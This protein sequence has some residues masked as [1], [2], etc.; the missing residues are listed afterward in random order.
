M[1]SS[2]L[3]STSISDEDLVG[4]VLGGSASGKVLFFDRFSP[5]VERVLYAVLGPDPEVADVLHEVFLAAFHG[6]RALRDPTNVKAWITS[7]AVYTARTW[8]RKRQRRRW[9][10]MFVEEIDEEPAP[11][12]SHEVTDALRAT[13][14]ILK[15]LPENDRIV[16][17]LRFI[18]GMALEEVAVVA[19]VSLST[20]KRRIA[21]AVKGFLGQARRV[22]ELET[23]IADGRWSEEWRTLCE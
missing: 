15:T 3:V 8:I 4:L 19:Q 12:A 16:F 9:F 18:E 7:V 13:Y 22:P 21:R 17:S 5:R 1:I 20:A 14:D 2:Q 6:L 11:F 23:W 10:H